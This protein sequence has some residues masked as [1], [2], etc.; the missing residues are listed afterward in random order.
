MVGGYNSAKRP[1]YVQVKVDA[2]GWEEWERF[3]GGAIINENYVLTAAHIFDEA[4]TFNPIIIVSDFM[5]EES[6]KRF[7]VA[8]KVIIHE[9][10]NASD[11]S[12]EY[13]IALIKI[14]T[15]RFC[16]V[17]TIPICDKFYFHHTIG[18][19]GMGTLQDGGNYSEVLQ[20]MRFHEAIDFPACPVYSSPTFPMDYEG[21]PIC[22]YGLVSWGPPNCTA[23]SVHTRVQ[24]YVDWI[25]ANIIN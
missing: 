17:K 10:Y 9:E 6:E 23:F 11:V 19:C 14:D 5:E 2:P 20:E 16:G 25:K 15:F 8:D 13:D 7:I 24:V 12:A 22:L 4:V 1:F 21:N 18:L 3:F